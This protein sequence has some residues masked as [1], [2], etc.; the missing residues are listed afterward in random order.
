M[1]YFRGLLIVAALAGVVLAGCGGG[2]QDNK[3]DDTAGQKSSAGG[4]VAL[5]CAKCGE[6]KGSD[7][8]CKLEGKEICDKCGLIKGS[9]G[10]CKIK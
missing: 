6:V 9:P 2:D 10:C 7:E 4:D 1:K 3:A 8:C 5:L